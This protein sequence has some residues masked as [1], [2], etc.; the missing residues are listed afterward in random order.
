VKLHRMRLRI[1]PDQPA[2]AAFDDAKNS[3]RRSVKAVGA[4]EQQT[5]FAM[6]ARRARVRSRDGGTCYVDCSD[7][8]RS[9]IRYR[10]RRRR[11]CFGLSRCLDR[12]ARRLRIIEGINGN[13][14]RVPLSSAVAAVSF[15]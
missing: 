9:G 3:V 7:N 14:D 10:S 5:G 15:E 8:S 2:V 4:G 12:N 6:S 1:Q 13:A 11:T